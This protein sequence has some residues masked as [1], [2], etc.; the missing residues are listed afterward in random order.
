ML[1]YLSHR[2]PKSKLLGYFETFGDVENYRIR[3]SIALENAEK[4]LSDEEAGQIWDSLPTEAKAFL[5]TIR[6]SRNRSAN[7]I[8][9]EDIVQNFMR[10]IQDDDLDVQNLNLGSL[11][12]R[13]A[14]NSL[15]GILKEV[16]E[17]EMN[18]TKDLVIS[19]LRDDLKRLELLESEVNQIQKGI[20]LDNSVKQAAVWK[21]QVKFYN[22]GGVPAVILPQAC[23]A[24]QRQAKGNSTIRLKPDSDLS[25]MV[26]SPGEALDVIFESYS[27]D[28]SEREFANLLK[29]A[30]D[31]KGRDF[32]VVFNTPEG[33]AIVSARANFSSEVNSAASNTIVEI[34]RDITI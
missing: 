12:R 4:A 5:F 19:V 7:N 25:N 14:L 16:T 17:I 2:E 1:Y 18:P 27:S 9:P 26:V 13:F 22:S 32:V 21:V 34:A 30:F 20:N 3:I 10:V 23:M 11:Q 24:L 33:N 8:S 29:S 28:E 31:E 6:S 15:P